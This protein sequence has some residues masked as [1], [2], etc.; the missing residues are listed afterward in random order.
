MQI[1]SKS[2]FKTEINWYSPLYV[3]L[4][5]SNIT[6][7]FVP[8]IKSNPP[9][10]KRK[11][12]LKK[13][14]ILAPGRSDGVETNACKSP[15]SNS[16]LL[17]IRTSCTRLHPHKGENLCRSSLESA[18]LQNRMHY[19]FPVRCC[20]DMNWKSPLQVHFWSYLLLTTLFK[21]L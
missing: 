1:E 17:P 21:G 13:E 2:K 6:L 7:I 18:L 8:K 20:P 11:R 12:R 16:I 3:T 5:R 14:N 15:N 19:N 9:K 10:L 4:R